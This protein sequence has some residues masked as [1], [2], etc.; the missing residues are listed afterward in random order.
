MLITKWVNYENIPMF[1]SSVF[2]LYIFTNINIFK[3]NNIFLYFAVITFNGS[4]VSIMFWS[5]PVLYRNTIIHRIDAVSARFIL[6]NYA[7]YKI[8]V[9]HNNLLWFLIYYFIML[10]FFYLSNKIS[11]NNWCC[12]K[13]INFHLLAHF[14]SII[15]FLLTINDFYNYKP[16]IF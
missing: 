10:V 1:T 14:F 9:N 12:K 5:N 2:P 3:Q 4:I 13:H 7:L 11:S 16:L 6:V 15:C 8:T